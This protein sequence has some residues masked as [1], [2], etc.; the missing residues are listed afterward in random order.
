[1]LNQGC[2]S[3]YRYDGL[4][5]AVSSCENVLVIL[6]KPDESPTVHKDDD[7]GMTLSY[8]EAT[9]IKTFQ[10]SWNNIGFYRSAS[11]FRLFVRIKINSISNL[12]N[13]IIVAL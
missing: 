1:M 10:T 13:I 6:K 8:D 12:I 2:Y 9:I 11:F 4:D 5:E 7:V 3:F